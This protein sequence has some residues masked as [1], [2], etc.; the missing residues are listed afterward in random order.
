MP[1]WLRKFYFK[2]TEEALKAESKAN[3]EATKKSKSTPTTPRVN[4]PRVPRK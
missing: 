2:K 4:I 3:E 1:T